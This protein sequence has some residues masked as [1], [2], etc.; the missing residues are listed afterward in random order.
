D[1]QYSFYMTDIESTI[2]PKLGLSFN[3]NIRWNSKLRAKYEYGVIDP[4]NGYVDGTHRG[5]VEFDE[6]DYLDDILPLDI[7]N[8]MERKNSI[9][10]DW[11]LNNY[12]ESYLDEL[13]RYDLE[14]VKKVYSCISFRDFKELINKSPYVILG[15]KSIWHS[16]LINIVD[17]EF[18]DKVLGYHKSYHNYL[19]EVLPL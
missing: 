3:H 8:E 5:G 19:D 12:N 9:V 15:N 10:I 18:C 17:L 4:F 11:L 14:L 1:A 7:V 13:D 16:T 2:S 6:R